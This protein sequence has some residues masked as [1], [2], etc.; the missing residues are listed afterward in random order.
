[1]KNLISVKMAFV[2][3]FV[4]GTLI[5]VLLFPTNEGTNYV[6]Q[7]E[8]VNELQF[9]DD[10]EIQQYTLQLIDSVN[11]ELTNLIKDDNIKSDEKKIYAE[12]HHSLNKSKEYI[13]MN[14]SIRN[15]NQYIDSLKKHNY[16]Y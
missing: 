9:N 6:E 1:M 16:G 12:F 4:L 7:V 11:V 2:L 5:S 13:K 14:M 8:L 3:T 10:P 15:T